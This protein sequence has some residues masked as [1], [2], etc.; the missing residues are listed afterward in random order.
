MQSS[1]DSVPPRYRRTELARTRKQV[2]G[3]NP[4]ATRETPVDG[5]T[6]DVQGKMLTSELAKEQPKDEGQ[7]LSADVA[8][9]GGPTGSALCEDP[10]QPPCG[11]S[12]AEDAPQVPCPAV[13]GDKAADP[14]ERAEVGVCGACCRPAS[15]EQRNATD[16]EGSAG[17]DDACDDKPFDRCCRSWLDLMFDRYFRVDVM[18]AHHVAN[19][20]SVLVLANHAGPFPYEGVMLAA[21]LRRAQPASRDVRWL[22]EDPWLGVPKLGTMLSHLGA[23]RASSENVE[24]VLHRDGLVVAF[25]EGLGGAAKLFKNRRS[26]MRFE[27]R[28]II[29]LGLRTRTPIVPCVV[30]GVE[31]SMPLLYRFE[32]WTDRFGLPFLPVTPTFPWFGLAG[33]VP[34]PTK[35]QIVFGEPFVGEEL[36]ERDRTRESEMD[37]LERGVVRVRGAMQGLL[38]SARA[39]RRSVWFG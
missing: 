7:V 31:E 4:F 34:A 18:G 2:L 11:A 15:V 3:A 26:L 24:R 38:N 21:A 16:R 6:N 32:R 1:Y 22:V 17:V 20:G 19:Q 10:V 5:Q 33:L 35:W 39:S 13:D 36:G 8:E 27:H 30:V 29:H 9:S 28:D 14:P 23:V 25:P 12:A 37:M